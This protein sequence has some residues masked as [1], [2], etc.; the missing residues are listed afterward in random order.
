MID[1][2]AIVAFS[3]PVAAL[4]L[5]GM[6]VV[7]HRRALHA[8]PAPEERARRDAERQPENDRWLEGIEDRALQRRRSIAQARAL[9][10]QV[11]REEQ[12][13]TARPGGD[14]TVPVT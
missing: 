5:G 14:T 13:R 11:E 12:A 2:F 10:D 4:A 3:V 8:E 9:L 7:L 1:W 6:A